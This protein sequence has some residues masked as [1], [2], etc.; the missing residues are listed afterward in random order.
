VKP[1]R[2]VAEA[3]LLIL[4]AILSG[5]AILLGNQS[6]AII[7]FTLLLVTATAQMIAMERNFENRLASA[8]AAIHGPRTLEL[9][10]QVAA[11]DWLCSALQKASE[12]R[13]TRI[14]VVR[15]GRHWDKSL[16]DRWRREVKE[17]VERGQGGFHE[18][19][20]ESVGH[21]SAL[22]IEAAKL[23]ATALTGSHTYKYV[24]V[25]NPGSAF[26]NFTLLDY[27]D[28]KEVVLGWGSSLSADSDKFIVV[29]GDGPYRL[30]LDLWDCLW[31]QGQPDRPTRTSG[32][33]K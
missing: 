6:F 11:Y 13:N 24:A 3:T 27:R 17:F 18:I 25:A 14:P 5:V 19:V 23:R 12:V 9:R 4:A 22:E 16:D 7:A 32:R 26:V 10:D 15:R 21:D 20:G 2:P 8:M 30:F 33:T 28:S 1:F 31:N 29:Q